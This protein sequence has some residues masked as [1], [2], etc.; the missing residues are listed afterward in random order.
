[1]AVTKEH[2]WQKRSVSGNKEREQQAQPCRRSWERLFWGAWWHS[3]GRH[4][5]RGGGAALRM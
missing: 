1:V 4:L 5:M 3:D 2:E